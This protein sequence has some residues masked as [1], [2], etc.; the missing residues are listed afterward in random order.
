MKKSPFYMPPGYVATRMDLVAMVFGCLL[1]FGIGFMMW[2]ERVE[3]PPVPKKMVLRSAYVTQPLSGSKSSA[4]LYFNVERG[5]S[6]YKYRIDFPSYEAE[7]LDVRKHKKLWVAVDAGSDNEFVW[8]V[9]DD[10][11]LLMMS[12]QQITQW[13]RVNNFRSYIMVAYS[14]LAIGYFVFFILRY[15]IFNRSC[16]RKVFNDDREN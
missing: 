15:G 13:A 1:M 3:V 14:G 5:E 2:N 8:A 12:R 16:H 11:L 6:Y 10:E 7:L 4:Y 9:Y